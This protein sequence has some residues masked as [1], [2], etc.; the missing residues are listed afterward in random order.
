[1]KSIGLYLHIPFCREKCP[2]CDFYSVGRL[3]QAAAYTAALAG[4]M[5]R[6]AED[7]LAADTLY[8]GGGTPT[9]LG[10]PKLL[11]LLETARRYYA[12]TGEATLE[13]NPNSVTPDML[14]AL[15]KAGFNRI[16]FGVQSAV[17]AELDAL[18]RKHTVG[19]SAQ[20]VAW[21]KEAGFDNISADM[22][23]GIPGQTTETALQTVSFLSSL[24]LQHISAYLLKIE[25]GTLF[26]RRDTA[27][28]CPDEAETCRIYLAVVSALE[29]AGFEQY[30]ISN[31]AKPG[32]Q[33]KHNLKYWHCEEYLGFGPAAHGFYNGL[34]Y[35]HSRRLSAYLA[36][37]EQTIF[38]TDE[39]A[40]EF[41]EYAMLRLRLTEGLGLKEAEQRFS[42]S[43]DNLRRRAERFQKAGLLKA[44]AERIVLTPQGFLVS[45]RLIA[46][47]IS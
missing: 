17:P 36:A 10:V 33:S 14:L 8:L 42:V 27:R 16:S 37:P 31:F 46:E 26:F 15:H 6:R 13:A 29:K 9:L 30:E 18:G 12:F 20:A 1:M 4:E 32:Y 2:Y 35:G 40:G 39:H 3:S 41:E 28:L 21:A 22:M 7:G 11:R 44:T 47:L 38:V 19:Q 24:G 45:N 23:L 25:E 5:E 43:A 34:R